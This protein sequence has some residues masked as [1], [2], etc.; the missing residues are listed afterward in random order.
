MGMKSTWSMLMRRYWFS[1]FVT[2]LVATGFI[3]GQSEPSKAKGTTITS[4]ESSE[5]TQKLKLTNARVS[6]TTEHVTDGKSALEVEFI[7]FGTV[8]IELSSGTPPWDWRSFGAIAFD[9]ANPADQEISVGLQL[10]D[11]GPGA[12]QVSGHGNVAPHDTVSYYYPIGSSSS[13][14]HGM[15]GG[16][17]MVPGVTPFSGISGS[18]SRLDERQITAFA[19]SFHYPAGVTKAIIDNVRLLPPFHYDAIVDPLGQYTRADWPGKVANAQ[20]LLAQKQQ[21]EGEIKAHPT[22][23]DRD[24]Y[25]GWASGPKVAATGFFGTVK[26]EGKW[27]LVD[28]DGHVFF[29]LGIDV[30]DARPNGDS[31]TFVEGRKTMFTW[32]PS[33]DDRLNKYYGHEDHAAYGPIKKGQTY[34]FYLANLHR[35]YGPDWQEAWRTSALDRLRAWGFNTIGNWSDPA[36][37]AYQKVPY[38]A[39][40]EIQGN[41]AHISSGI[42]Y[43]G[44]M[45]DPFDPAFARAVDRS[46]QEG[47]QKYR[48]DPWCIGYFVDNEISWGGNA[49]D[50]EHY[51]LVYGTLSGGQ[52]SPAK[53]AF[54][55]QLKLR[56]SSV[57]RLNQA[58]G[59]TFT[60]W[61]ALL[62][63]PYHAPSSLAAP[64]RDDFTKFL[65]AF[66]DQYFK[67]IREALRKY[68]AHHLYLG[69]RFAWR[70]PEAV[71][72]A[73]RYA[74]VV[75]FNI[76]R[77]HLDPEEWGFA[78]SLNKPCII[79]EF[80]F[81]AVDRGM[82]HTGLVATPN[83]QARAAMYKQYIES[84][85]DN[86]AFVGCHWFQYY[87]EPL[88]GRAYDGE[89]YNI[90]FISVTDTPY[91]EMVKG[92]KAVQSELYARRGRE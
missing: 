60:S 84:V 71:N 44:K 39:T 32:L 8:S 30:I 54:V 58:W 25:G 48:D 11:A 57:E 16:P 20:G 19:I 36:L 81:G 23:A 55:A 18:D 34:S 88:T 50:K 42:D 9:V 72:A 76:Y 29:S 14:E 12:H 65:T 47:T 35:K 2:S 63:Q 80:H 64:M 28:P 33:S 68:D 37:Y 83:Q 89:N 51:G 73:A 77:S 27:W 6:L 49:N 92:A 13:L 40:I 53:Q 21:E 7:R 61:P 3:R 66:A 52:D 41:Y 17:P 38:T 62:E 78:T 75:S 10:K 85:E 15:R 59:T 67:T 31:F 5:D 91:P 86:R 82:F 45:H 74:D 79:G 56:Y 46:V 22:V 43:W 4:F 87:D 69:C 26:R 70:T 24:R 1:F 90:G